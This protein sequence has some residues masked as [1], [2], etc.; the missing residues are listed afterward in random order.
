VSSINIEELT[1]SVHCDAGYVPDLETMHVALMLEYVAAWLDS[2]EHDE[3]PSV[4]AANL[5]ETVA[6]WR[7][8]SR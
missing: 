7:E 8:G 3:S 6:R 1:D 5:R 2:Q 4:L